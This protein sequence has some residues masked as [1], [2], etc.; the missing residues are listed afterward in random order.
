MGFLSLRVAGA[1]SLWLMCTV[2]VLSA[3]VGIGFIVC[4]SPELPYL[5]AGLRGEC[6]AHHSRPVACLSCGA[7]V[8]S[9]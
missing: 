2:R 5:R 6:S 3:A 4:P 1:G 8:E 7:G 9:N